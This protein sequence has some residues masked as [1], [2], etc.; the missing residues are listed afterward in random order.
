MDDAPENEKPVFGVELED[1]QARGEHAGGDM[2]R[3]EL[4]GQQAPTAEL[5]TEIREAEKK[6]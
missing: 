6:A 1:N 5:P 2:R 4:H 3:S